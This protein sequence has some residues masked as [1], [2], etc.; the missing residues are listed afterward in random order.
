M[1]VILD[2]SVGIPLLYVRPRTLLSLTLRIQ[3]KAAIIIKGQCLRF[4]IVIDTILSTVFFLSWVI[5]PKF[6]PFMKK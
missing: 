3:S 4:F 6:W 1:A 5:S 2:S